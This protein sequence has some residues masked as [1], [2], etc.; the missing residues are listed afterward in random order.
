MG[1][2]FSCPAIM[3]KENVEIIPDNRIGVRRIPSIVSII[4]N[5]ECLIRTT[6]KNNILQSPES[7]MFDI[8]RLI[9]YKYSK[10]NLKIGFLR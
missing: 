9:G 4:I 1:I 7:I 2:K 10:I 5:R 8:K 3:R 6:A